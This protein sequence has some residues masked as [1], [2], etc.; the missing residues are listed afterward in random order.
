MISRRFFLS[1][2]QQV[3]QARVLRREKYISLEESI[4]LKCIAGILLHFKRFQSRELSQQKHTSLEELI[5]LEDIPSKLI[6]VQFHSIISK[7]NSL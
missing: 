5:E 7:I 2:F 1:A 3:F 4:T 6:D